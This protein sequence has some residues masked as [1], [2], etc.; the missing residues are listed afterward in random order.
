M[1][2]AGPRWAEPAI[3]YS[4][5]DKALNLLGKFDGR[6]QEGLRAIHAEVTH[7]RRSREPFVNIDPYTFFDQDIRVTN[8]DDTTPMEKEISYIQI[9]LRDM[10]EYGIFKQIV[11]SCEKLGLIRRNEVKPRTHHWTDTYIDYVEMEKYVTRDIDL[12]TKMQETI[13]RLKL[14]TV[15]TY[16]T[17]VQEPKVEGSPRVAKPWHQFIEDNVRKK[18]K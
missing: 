1:M 3:R 9:E 6:S 18:L 7:W 4:D 8:V 13:K 12:V 11:E 17:T 16:R 15:Q 2:G 5:R 10:S 14:D